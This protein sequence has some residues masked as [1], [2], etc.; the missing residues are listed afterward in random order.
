MNKLKLTALAVLAV[1][2]A[3]C[4]GFSGVVKESNV[5]DAVEN[6]NSG[7]AAALVEDSALPFVFDGEI[8]ESETQLKL[9]WNGL[10]DAGFTIDN[11]MIVQQRPV[12]SKDS[13]LFSGYW[14]VQT[15][16][17][18]LTTEDDFFVEVQGAGTSAY[19]IFRSFPKE[20]VK[21]RAFKGVVQ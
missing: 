9:L 13:E 7:N 2:M 16:F 14:E 18:N 1:S 11:P 20:G 10:T 21:I 8:L 6:L 12:A 3:S 17:K 5:M 15:W 19:M 4:A